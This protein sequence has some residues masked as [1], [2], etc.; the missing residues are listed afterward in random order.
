MTIREQIAKHSARFREADNLSPHDVAQ[1]LV[2]LTSLLA[3]LNTEIVQANYNYNVVINNLRK[4][5]KSA[6]DAKIQAQATPEWLAWKERE[7]QGEALVE[8]IRSAK[9]YLAMASDEQKLQ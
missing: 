4:T 6:V 8:L 3:S 7:K 1:R 9:K 2:E 5:T